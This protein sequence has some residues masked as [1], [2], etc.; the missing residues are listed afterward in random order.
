MHHKL[1]VCIIFSLQLYFIRNASLKNKVKT[2]AQ[3]DAFFAVE[4]VVKSVSA[5]ARNRSHKLLPQS[6]FY[7][8]AH[9]IHMLRTHTH[10]SILF[11]LI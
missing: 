9:S 10:I 4:I 6:F 8:T 5:R 11:A 2:E 1:H 7:T 3:R